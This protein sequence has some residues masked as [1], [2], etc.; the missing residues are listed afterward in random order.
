MKAFIHICFSEMKFF[1]QQMKRK[2]KVIIYL[3][4]TP[5]NFTP[6]SPFVDNPEKFVYNFF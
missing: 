2:I 5:Q 4:L 3:F 1:I 6:N